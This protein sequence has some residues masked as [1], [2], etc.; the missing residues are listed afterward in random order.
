MA[1]HKSALK[2]SKQDLVRRMRNRSGRSS[3]RTALKNFR[4]ELANG[5]SETAEKLPQIHS[6]IDKSAKKGFIHRNA[7]ARLKSHLSQQAAKLA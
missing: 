1:N 6:L 2:K 7:A 3:L 5:S 4:A